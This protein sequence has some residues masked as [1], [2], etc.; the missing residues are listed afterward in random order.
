[1]AWLLMELLIVLLV[2]GGRRR[3]FSR[4][5]FPWVREVESR[6]RDVRQDLDRVMRY[7]DRIPNFQDTTTAGESISNNDQWKTFWF[8]VAGRRVEENCALCPATVAVLERIPGMTSAFYSILAP[9]KHVPAHRGMYKGVLRL[10][11]GLLVPDP[12]S[13]CR[14]RVD[15]EVRHWTEG[16]CLLFDDRYEHEVWND[17][18]TDRV[19]L[20][21]DFIRPMPWPLNRWNERIIQRLGCA[22]FTEETLRKTRAAAFALPPEQTG[23]APERG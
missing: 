20:F 7:R 13:S 11:L 4:E 10:H 3:F 6:W 5:D 8:Y 17:A 1:M 2:Q 18:S 22:E 16:E 9:G 19:V 23:P 12:P 14:I 21:V 15:Q